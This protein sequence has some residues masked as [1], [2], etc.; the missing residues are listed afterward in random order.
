MRERGRGE[1]V[2]QNKGCGPQQIGQHLGNAQR[3]RVADV[4]YQLQKRGQRQ[5]WYAFFHDAATGKTRSKYVGK[6]FRELT[7]SDF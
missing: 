6:A 3:Q 7:G 1:A 5:Y 4:A 2:Y